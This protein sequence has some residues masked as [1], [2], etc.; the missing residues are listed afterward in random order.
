LKVMGSRT[1]ARS[2]IDAPDAPSASRP[3]SRALGFGLLAGTLTGFALIGLIAAPLFLWAMATEP[4]TGLQR[5]AVRSGLRWAPLLG[6]IAFSVTAVLCT[7]W[8]LTHE[9]SEAGPE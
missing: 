5:P 6:L 7:R 8:R 9:T 1:S 3:W 4:G 2:E